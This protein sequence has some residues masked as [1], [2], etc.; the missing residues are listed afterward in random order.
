MNEYEI[1]CTSKFEGTYTEEEVALNNK[2]YKECTKEVIDCAA[3]EE[4]LRQGADPLGATAVS[5][6]GLLDHV[7]EKLVDS[8]DENFP[9]I[10][11]LFLKHGMNI[12][13]PRIPYD[14]DNSIN[15]L[16]SFAFNINENTLLSL[17]MLLDNG[18]SANSVGDMWGHATFDLINIE[19]GNPNTDEFW[20]NECI[21]TMRT[22]M[23]CA[24]YDRILNN[25]EDMRDF[26]GYSYNDYDLH[27]FRQWEEFIYEFDTSHCDRHPE[28]YKSVVRIYEK[29][30]G[31]EVWKVGICLKEGEF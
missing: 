12:D 25:D 14:N 13:H 31:K 26:I 18:L 7:Y 30:T 3:I 24:S 19:C 21:W 16:W 4:L 2:L 5:G 22:I 9:V 28:F 6:W 15:P 20:R 1:E 11:E 27:K 8:D 10:T 17:K 23:F 29:E